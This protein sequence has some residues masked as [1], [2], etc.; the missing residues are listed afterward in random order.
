MLKGK[1]IIL[2]PVTPDDVK[3]TI[4]LRYDFEANKQYLGYIF[5]INL[6]NEQRW[7][8]SLY[9]QRI[10]E[11]IDLVIEEK[12]THRFIG[13]IGVNN[14]DYINKRAKFGIFIK[15]RYWGKGFG[16]EAMRIFLNYLFNQINL[17]KIYLE[18]LTE[19]QRAIKLYKS[20][21]FEPEGILKAHYYQDGRYKDVAIYSI[22]KDKFCS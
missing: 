21:G 20:M 19:N 1:R 13:L 2:R 14:I 16:K 9:S 3:E 12:N 18:V 22:F 6:T 8:E 4:S 10:R 11:R 5:P 7:I 15:R 17:N